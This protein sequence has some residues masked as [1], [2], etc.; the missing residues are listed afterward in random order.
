[1]KKILLAYGLPKE[2]VAAIM[3]LNRYTKVKVRSRDKDTDYFDIV[4]GYWK[5]IPWPHTSLSSIQ[6]TCLEHQSIKSNKTVSSRQRKEAEGTLLKQLPTPT[7][8]KTIAILANTPAQ[9]ETQLHCL[10][11]ASAGIGH[12]NAH[13]TEHMCYNQTGDISTQNSSSLKLID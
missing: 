12:V 3:I 4:A 10:G 5:E 7:T 9:S 13:K 11:R 2:T 6:T 8:L 1:M